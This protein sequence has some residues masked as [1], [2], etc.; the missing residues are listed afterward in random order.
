MVYFDPQKGANSSPPI[1]VLCFSNSSLPKS[2]GSQYREK[3]LTNKCDANGNCISHRK[4][5]PEIIFQIIAFSVSTSLVS[6]ENSYYTD[7]GDINCIAR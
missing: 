3:S 7:N 5:D 2:H 1:H 4:S 6:D